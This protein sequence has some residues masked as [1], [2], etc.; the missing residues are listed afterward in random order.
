MLFRTIISLCSIL[1]S[2]LMI[3]GTFTPTKV[4]R[5]SVVGASFV[6]ATTINKHAILSSPRLFVFCLKTSVTSLIVISGG[7]RAYALSQSRRMVECV[8]VAPVCVRWC[9]TPRLSEGTYIQSFF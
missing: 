7:K 1:R 3:W 2:L 4:K 9:V 5:R 8:F 6:N